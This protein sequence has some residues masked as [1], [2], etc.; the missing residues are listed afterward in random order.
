MY[1]TQIKPAASESSQN[2]QKV[3]Q[4]QLKTQK[5]ESTSNQNL[6]KMNQTQMKN[7]KE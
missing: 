2:S 5:C 3:S 1:E 6:Q 7:S 4:S